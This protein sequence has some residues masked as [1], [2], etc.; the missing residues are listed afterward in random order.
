MVAL[1]LTDSDLVTLKQI[2]KMALLLHRF[3][4][5][6]F[7]SNDLDARSK[8]LAR[9]IFFDLARRH[10]AQSSE[11]T[12]EAMEHAISNIE[13]LGSSRPTGCVSL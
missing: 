4:L 3:P 13:K 6:Y 12:L 1:D 9:E 10:P 7:L 5:E 11:S 2:R 8:A